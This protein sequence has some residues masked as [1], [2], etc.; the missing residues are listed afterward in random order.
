V[1]LSVLA[2]EDYAIVVTAL[3]DGSSGTS[4]L[5]T[6]KSDKGNIK[7]T[8]PG[9]LKVK[10]KRSRKALKWKG[11]Q[12]AVDIDLYRDG[13]RFRAIKHDQS[14]KLFRWTYGDIPS[15]ENYQIRITQTDND[16]VYGISALFAIAAASAS[17]RQTAR[18]DKNC[19][20]LGLSQKCTAEAVER[21]RV[22]CQDFGIGPPERCKGGSGEENRNKLWCE[23]LGIS[24]DCSLAEIVQTVFD[25]E[26]LCIHDNCTTDRIEEMRSRKLLICRAFPSISCESMS[27]Y[28]GD[29]CE[30][31]KEY[32]DRLQKLLTSL[33]SV[34]EKSFR[35]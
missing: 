11:I 5:F 3:A 1:S 23:G 25:C 4:D 13:R 33:K 22:Q 15:G 34:S 17:D 19:K 14:K 35:P 27:E 8:P 9:T 18:L 12:A 10:N 24:G 16:S 21:V 30:S 31:E 6:I 2:G 32:K 7:V 28:H 29:N 26:E 20:R